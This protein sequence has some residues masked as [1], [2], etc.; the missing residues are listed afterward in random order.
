MLDDQRKRIVLIDD[1]ALVRQGLERLLNLGDEFVVCEEA[2]D[3]DQ[4]MMMV[5]EMQ[6]DAVVVDVELPGADGIEITKALLKDF[7]HLTV[8]V[9]SAHQEPEMA[10]RAMEAGAMAYVVKSEGI[11][12]LLAA[13]RNAFNRKRSF[14]VLEKF[15]RIV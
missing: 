1:H 8:I 4:G 11:D 12:A 14:A 9:L 10:V 5:R 13:L 6:P 2:G 15:G 3:A 7:P